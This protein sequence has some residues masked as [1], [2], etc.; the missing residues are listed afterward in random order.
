MSAGRI[1]LS[2]GSGNDDARLRSFGTGCVDNAC[3]ESTSGRE[4]L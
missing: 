3:A 1:H 2:G 4:R